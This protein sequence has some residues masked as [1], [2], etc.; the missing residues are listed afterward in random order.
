[1]TD[2]RSVKG[3]WVDANPDFPCDFLFID[4]KHTASEI[5]ACLTKHAP[6]VRKWIAL[7][8]TQKF[9][10]WGEDGGLGVLPGLRAFVKENMAE[11]CVKSDT[12]AGGGLTVISRDPADRPAIEPGKGK[13]VFNFAVAKL[14]M[15]AG[16]VTG[17]LNIVPE[18]VAQE[19][20]DICALCPKRAGDRCSKCG[21]WLVEVP[22]GQPLAGHPGRAMIA[23]MP[24]P[25]AKWNEYTP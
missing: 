6:N 14:K 4:I 22:D 18:E 9:G 21:C 19:R 13:Q 12:D 5:L 15:W 7:Y 20:L 2:L 16:K 25:L 1:V 17:Q 8:G 11:W 10:E 24:C 3:S 23:Q